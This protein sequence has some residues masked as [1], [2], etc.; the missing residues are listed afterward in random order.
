MSHHLAS[1][2]F[3]QLCQ[4]LAVAC[5][6]TL[7]RRL[8]GLICCACDLLR[9]PPALSA[10]PPV[11]PFFIVPPSTLGLSLTLVLWLPSPPT[12]VGPSVPCLHLC[13]RMST[14][15]APPRVFESLSPSC[16]SHSHFEAASHTAA[17]MSFAKE[18]TFQVAAIVRKAC[19]RSRPLLSQRNC[20]RHNL[21]TTCI[22]TAR[23][24]F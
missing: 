18:V 14:C 1:A 19:F 3:P 17:S 22:L 6:S 21:R 15:A 16:G 9:H 24:H 7:R 8:H 12:D 5:Y 23:C 4:R 20:C 2:A 10:P 13:V 11:F